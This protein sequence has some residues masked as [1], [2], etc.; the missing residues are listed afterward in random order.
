MT[1]STLRVGMMSRGL[2][3][4]VAGC[5]YR[6]NRPV[7][8]PLPE[9]HRIF[10]AHRPS[11]RLARCGV[12]AILL[13]A[14]DRMANSA[15]SQARGRRAASIRRRRPLGFVALVGA[16]IAGGCQPKTQLAEAPPK[17]P[18]LVLLSPSPGAVLYTNQLAEVRA[19]FDPLQPLGRQEISAEVTLRGRDGTT[20]TLAEG[21]LRTLAFTD[22]L[23]TPVDLGGVKPEDYEIIVKVTAPELRGRASGRV[24]VRAPPEGQLFVENAVVLRD[25][26]SVTLG[27]RV[28]SPSGA[29]IDSFIWNF[30]DDSISQRTMEPR[31]T[32]TYQRGANFGISVEIRDQN[33][34]SNFAAGTL[35]VSD[36]GGREVRFKAAGNFCACDEMIVFHDS[37]S[38][39]YC[40][41]ERNAVAFVDDHPTCQIA[42][43]APA[44]ACPAFQTAVVCMRGPTQP[45]LAGGKRNFGFTFEAVAYLRDGSTPGACPEGQYAKGTRRI[46]G[47]P[48][49][50]RTVNAVPAADGT[51]RTEPPSGAQRLRRDDGTDFDF[52]AEGPGKRYPR[53]RV[54]GVNFGPDNYHKPGKRGNGNKQHASNQI[55]WIDLPGLRIRPGGTL[56]SQNDEFISF[57]RDSGGG[58]AC[59]CHFAI[60]QVWTRAGGNAG[61]GLRIIDDGARCSYVPRAPRR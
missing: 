25:G 41:D 57:V 7:I 39:F 44:G 1:N 47:R 54:G 50:N 29:H 10:A 19:R 60:Q 9:A 46:D 20:F 40:T 37:T 6:R 5:S 28:K 4:T 35:D 43:N 49:Q 21:D 3:A 16:L 38:A 23:L 11:R 58:G 17:A 12:A 48:L 36:R 14:G 13:G 22:D 26:V 24:E 33:G 8:A 15:R 34:G 32:H 52:T 51:L 27:A 55:R 61:P 42:D 56:A 31:V 18:E 30:G 2:V 59:W 53:F 45:D